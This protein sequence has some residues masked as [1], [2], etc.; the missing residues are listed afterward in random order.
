M[1][2]KRLHESCYI[3]KDFNEF[4]DV[5]TDLKYVSYT[6]RIISIGGQFD[7]N[8][9]T[10]KVKNQRT[11]FVVTFEL[12]DDH[13]ENRWIYN[14]SSDL[15]DS[16][17]TINGIRYD[18]DGRLSELHFKWWILDDERLKDRSIKYLDVAGEIREIEKEIIELEK[19]EEI[20]LKYE[21]FNIGQLIR[22]KKAEIRELLK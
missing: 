18:Y 7:S 2:E 5:Y 4:F 14:F 19:V 8:E 12:V 13:T 9:Y 6:S 15:E 20:L 11:D 22:D 16:D 21:G 3:E 17:D 10:V 1:E